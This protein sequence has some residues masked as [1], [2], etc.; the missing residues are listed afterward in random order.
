MTSIGSSSSVGPDPNFP[1]LPDFTDEKQSS[2]AETLPHDKVVKSEVWK[3]VISIS[4]I[5]IFSVIFMV[6]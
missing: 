4:L 5:D 1:P 2:Q 3:E 6:L